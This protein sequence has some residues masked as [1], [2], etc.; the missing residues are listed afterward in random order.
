MLRPKAG[1]RAV[2]QQLDGAQRVGPRGGNVADGVEKHRKQPVRPGQ[3]LLVLVVGGPLVDLADQ[4]ATGGV[5]ADP[6]EHVGLDQLS[7][8]L[9]VIEAEL[10]GLALQGDS[11]P[12]GRFGVG[13]RD[14]LQIVKLGRELAGKAACP[15]RF[16]VRGI[17]TEGSAL[18]SRAWADLARCGRHLFLT[19]LRR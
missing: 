6:A 4:L 11:R 1:G 7:S 5:L 12:E 9:E 15:S 10:A 19:V 3:Q 16:V 17:R 14:Q 8:P 2:V 18:G 13:E